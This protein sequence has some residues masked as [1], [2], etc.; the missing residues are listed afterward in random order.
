MRLHGIPTDLISDR[1]PIFN[2][3]F[4]RAFV[5]GLGIKPNFSTAFHPQSDGQ[6]ERVNQVLE[7]YL[8]VYCNYDQSN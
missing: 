5:T 8:R 2:S 4:W 1:G 7:Q 6:T 3:K